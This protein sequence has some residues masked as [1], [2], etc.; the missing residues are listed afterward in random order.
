MKQVTITIRKGGYGEV[1]KNLY[2]QFIEQLGDC[3]MGGL[4][5]K[6]HPLSDESGIRQDVL[7]KV[8]M[9]AP[10]VIRF[11]GGTVMSIY[12]WEDA[13]GALETRKKRKNLIW[14]GVLHPD[15][16]TAEFVEYCRRVGAE[17]MLCVNMASGTPEEAAHWVE[18]CNSEDDTYYANLRRSHG[19]EKPFGVKY[20]CIGNEC[21]A[22]PDIGLQ[23]DVQ[24]YIREAREF[25]KF[26]KLQDPTIQTVMVGSDDVDGWDRPVLDALGD[27][28]DYLSY[29]FYASEADMGLYGPF[30]GE[31]Q[32][33]DKLLQ[34]DVLLDEYPDKPEHFNVW[35]RFPPR[36]GKIKLLIDEWNIWQYQDDGCYGLHMRYNWRD[37]V[38]TASMLNRLISDEH[39]AGA[40]MA[41]L[42]NIIAPII[43]EQSGSFVQTIFTPC[44]LYRRYMH[45]IRLQPEI[46]GQYAV[47]GG[48]AGRI[49][50][51]S[52]AAVQN[53]DMSCLALVNRDFENAV[54]V[55][56]P[57]EFTSAVLCHA[58]PLAQNDM[59]QSC[60]KKEELIL[61]KKSALMLPSGALAII[62]TKKENRL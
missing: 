39:I 3:V 56:L 23:N 27:M 18:Y 42:C 11:P 22:E 58:A 9:L 31:K 25:V 47:D 29:H 62:F 46:S 33:A 54:M 60:V 15:F 37:A 17:P 53:G 32:F 5:E 41:Q 36:Q 19:Y 57:E 35:Y 4:Y 2:G 55:S 16:G 50:A 40:N 51:I 59:T 44:A 61:A 14:G 13:I 26:M 30:Y 45:G 28:T 49:A 38:W 10:S 52:A 21:Y 43:A 24:T 34:L 6:G 1:S 20:W 48:K 8:K 12:H 7:D